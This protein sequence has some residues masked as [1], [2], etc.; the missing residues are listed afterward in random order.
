MTEAERVE[1]L[2]NADRY[3]ASQGIRLVD[4]SP[5]SITVA[6]PLTGDHMNFYDV[7]HGGA[8]FSLADCAFSLAS[9]AH[10]DRAV[11]IDTHLALTAGTVE[12]DE[13][14]AV[15]EEVTRGRTLA[16]YRI[17]ITRTDGR[18]VGLFTG[19]VFVTPQV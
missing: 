10:G 4:P 9:N 15:A 7:T 16:T 2:F 13:L 18:T 8:L 12:G 1:A 5:G 11:A 3:A 17:T 19:T 6:M 14:T